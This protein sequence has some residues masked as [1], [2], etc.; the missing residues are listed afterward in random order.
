MPGKEETMA[1]EY[2]SK[3]RAKLVVSVG[4]ASKG[5]RRRYTKIIDITGK[6]N[7][8]DQYDDFV[9]EVKD[10]ARGK[11]GRAPKPIDRDF[12]INTLG[13]PENEIIDDCA[14]EDAKENTVAQFRDE[15]AGKGYASAPEEDV[16]S[17][18]LFPQVAEEFFKSKGRM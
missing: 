18:A 10:L 15:L 13:I 9:K 14:K 8:K 6:K 12:L 5:T 2:L 16:L 1:I 3:K 17:Y 4:S 11:F 7:A